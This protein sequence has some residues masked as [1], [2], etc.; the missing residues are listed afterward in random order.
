MKTF[1]FCNRIGIAKNIFTN[2]HKH[3]QHVSL[4]EDC[5]DE[6]VMVRNTG[7]RIELKTVTHPSQAPS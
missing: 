6:K 4:A 2:D 5:S 3:E 7:Q 1:D